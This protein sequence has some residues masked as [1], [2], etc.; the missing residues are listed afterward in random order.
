MVYPDDRGYIF[1][2]ALTQPLC[3]SA[4]RPIP[5]WA[6]KRRH[7]DGYS[8]T[9][10]EIYTKTLEAGIGC[11]GTRV[12]DSDTPRE[13]GHFVLRTPFYCAVL[14]RVRQGRRLVAIS[15]RIGLRNAGPQRRPLAV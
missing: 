11:P 13:T 8:S 9:F 12:V 7:L 1:G 15:T 14:R 5:T 2:K 10:G 6:G 4:A 3:D